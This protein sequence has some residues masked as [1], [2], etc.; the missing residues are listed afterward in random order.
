VLKLLSDYPLVT[1]H[2]IRTTANLADY[3]TRQG[4]P[5]GDLNKIGLKHMEIEN[6]H[7]KLPKETFTLEEWNT[8][9]KE[10]PQYLTIMDSDV[11]LTVDTQI[12]SRT[13]EKA[14]SQVLQCNID[15][16][17]TELMEFHDNLLGKSAN[18]AEWNEF[19]Q[20]NPQH[21]KPEMTSPVIYALTQ[22]ISNLQDLINPLEI[23]KNRLERNII[24]ENQKLEF[25]EIYENCQQ[26]NDFKVIITEKDNSVTYQLQVDLLLIKENRDN[27]YRIL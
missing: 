17:N 14:S 26:S 5:K 27:R 10:N 21:L 9:C 20:A 23:L 19:C 12:V 4:L 22:G 1:L 3:L 24:I 18:L 2:F 16:E 7:D 11:N 15:W 25:Q 13:H 8:F 6:F